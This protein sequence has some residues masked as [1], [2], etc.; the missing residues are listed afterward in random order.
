M[1]GG[2]RL[3][4]GPRAGRILND[5]GEGSVEVR[6]QQNLGWLY[7]GDRRLFP[8]VRNLFGFLNHPSP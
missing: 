8:G 1:D 6:N 2:E 4:R 7:S 5:L 3:G